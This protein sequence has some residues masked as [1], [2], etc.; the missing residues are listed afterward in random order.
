MNCKDKPK[1]G[2]DHTKKQKCLRRVCKAE[3]E[4]KQEGSKRRLLD[5]RLMQLYSSISEWT[6]AEGVQ[7]I[8]VFLK[9]PSRKS[10]PDYYDVITKPIDMSMIDDRIK[11]AHYGTEE[12]MID[13][14]KL[15]FSNCR[16]YNEEH[17]EIYEYADVLE[18]VLLAKA[19]EMGAGGKKQKI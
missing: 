4:K 9:K 12:E 8:R 10:Y 2:G 11:G 1:F 7:P 16:L 3:V 19:K 18:A 17:S 13:D 6:N 15:M 14:F 5:E